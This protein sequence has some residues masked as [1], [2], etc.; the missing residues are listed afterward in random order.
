MTLTRRTAWYHS[1]HCIGG[2]V[3]VCSGDI[4]ITLSI[5]LPVAIN[6]ESDSSRRIVGLGRYAI[7]GFREN[8]RK[9][10]VELK[11]KPGI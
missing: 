5:S 11:Y 3:A 6:H 2:Q 1:D 9:P 7:Y 4:V 8:P 10:D